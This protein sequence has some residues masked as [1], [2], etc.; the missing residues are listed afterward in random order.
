VTDEPT[1]L[2]ERFDRALLY[3]VHVHGGQ[4]RKRTGVPYVAHLLAVC[5]TV[6]E[7]GGDEDMAI[8]ALLHDAAEDQGGAPRLSDIEA[9]FGAR[10][11]AIVE[12]LSDN[13]A[14]Q[15]QTRPSWE[16]R[17]CRHLDQLQSASPDVL[18]VALAD[19]I[20]NTRS[21][22]RDLRRAGIGEGVWDKFEAP[23]ERTLWFYG[24]LALL[25]RERLPGQL[26][27]E[28]GEIVAVL[29]DETAP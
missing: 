6:L 4:T 3:A 10:V 29:R 21:V 7:Y 27:D 1:V 15:G 28:L 16:A 14:T 18:L 12:T 2:G 11:A 26:A 19:K 5:A 13:L 8:A 23:K 17:K 20:H 24:Q 9:R 22:L 25:F